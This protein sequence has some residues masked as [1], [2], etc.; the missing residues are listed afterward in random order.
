LTPNPFSSI[1][2]EEF[3]HRII[4][5][6]ASGLAI[7]HSSLILLKSVTISVSRGSSLT[8]FSI[9]FGMTRV[10]SSSMSSRYF[11]ETPDPGSQP[12]QDTNWTI[13]T[14]RLWMKRTPLH[15]PVKRQSSIARPS[16]SR[17]FDTCRLAN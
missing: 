4:R 7:I 14:A 10:G 11:S 13:G 9:S 5:I 6:V 15:S 2:N 8:S 17:H 16:Q 12:F 3:A 1:E